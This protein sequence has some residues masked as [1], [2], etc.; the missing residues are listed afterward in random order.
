M[1][2]QARSY[3]RPTLTEVGEFA[4]LTQGFFGQAFDG[5][6]MYPYAFMNS[7]W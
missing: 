2:D 4:D 1:T 6:G 5:G 3:E 7:T